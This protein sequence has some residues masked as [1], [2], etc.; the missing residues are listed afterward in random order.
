MREIGRWCYST[1]SYEPYFVPPNWK[2]VLY[3]DNMD[4]PINCTSC[5]KPM[6]YGQGYTSRELHSPVGF[7]YPVCE[8]CYAEENKRKEDDR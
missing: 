5:G 1:H 2:I 6:T 7:G 8:S 4:E 3:T